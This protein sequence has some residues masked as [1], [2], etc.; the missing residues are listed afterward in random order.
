MVNAE[1]DIDEGVVGT[2]VTITGEGFAPDEFVTLKYDNT[3]I[4]NYIVIYIN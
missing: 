1:I 4:N 3:V 2:E